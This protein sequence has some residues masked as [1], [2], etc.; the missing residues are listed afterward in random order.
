MPGVIGPNPPFFIPQNPVDE[1]SLKK[2]RE[3]EIGKCPAC[4]R[5]IRYQDI[6]GWKTI[7]SP[8]IPLVLVA[9]FPIYPFF[10]RGKWKISGSCPNCSQALTAI[11]RDYTPLY[12]AVHWRLEKTSFL[13]KLIKKVTGL[14]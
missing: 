8:R 9:P 13:S 6:E 2:A 4:G 3:R 7:E 12:Q 14:G 1:D 10:L 5:T 11:S